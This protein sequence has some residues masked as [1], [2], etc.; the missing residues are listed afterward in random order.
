MRAVAASES[1]F[2]RL[3]DLHSAAAAWTGWR[4]VGGSD[5]LAIIAV[6][7]QRGRRRRKQLAAKFD[8]VS[9]M[10]V[11]EQAVMTNT[12][13]AVRQG[14]HQKA[15]DELTGLERHRLALAVLR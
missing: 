14:V 8:L 15:P 6:V 9:A 13:E 5:L 7:V 10:T 12:M 2:N 4:F 11:G 1:S 3:N